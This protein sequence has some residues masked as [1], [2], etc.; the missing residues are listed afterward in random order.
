MSLSTAEMEAD[1]GPVVKKK[2]LDIIKERPALKN[3][4]TMLKSYNSI[5]MENEKEKLDYLQEFNSSSSS[6]AL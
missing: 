4:F 6:F 2:F 3:Y 5:K 1:G